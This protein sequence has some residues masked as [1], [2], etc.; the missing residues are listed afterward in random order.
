MPA[1]IV[2]DGHVLVAAHLAHACDSAIEARRMIESR[3]ESRSLEVELILV[4][5]LFPEDF[6]VPLEV[7]EQDE[8]PALVEIDQFLHLVEDEIQFSEQFD[9]WKYLVVLFLNERMFT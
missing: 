1:N 3:P 6:M 4:V 7:F 5:V 9:E 2:V 8:A